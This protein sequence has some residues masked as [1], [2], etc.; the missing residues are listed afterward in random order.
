MVVDM[1]KTFLIKQSIDVVSCD[2]EG[3]TALMSVEN[4][5]YY[6]L[7]SIGSRIWGLLT[8]PLRIAEICDILLKDFEVEPA[9]CEQEVQA[10]LTDLLKENL[11]EIIDE[12]GK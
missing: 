6:S 3:E 9:R 4:G 11:I 2:I 7:D 1:N 8:N 5:K 12:P 10:F